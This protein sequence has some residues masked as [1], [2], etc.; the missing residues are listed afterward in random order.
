MMVEHPQQQLRNSTLPIQPEHQPH[1]QL[2]D[3]HKFIVP[4]TTTTTSVIDTTTITHHDQDFYDEEIDVDNGHVI[5]NV[6][7]DSNTIKQVG[8]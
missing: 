4:T 6:N 8:I 2:I 1:Q 5:I 3:Q 7:N